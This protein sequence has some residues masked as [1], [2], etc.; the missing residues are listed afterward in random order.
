MPQPTTLPPL[1]IGVDLPPNLSAPDAISRT[2]STLPPSQL[3]DILAQMKALATNDPAKAAELLRQAPQL[4]YAIFQAML[5]MNLVSTEALGAVVE[6]A[7]A[8][9]PT[10]APVVQQPYAPPMAQGFA[11][12]QMGTP[13]VHGMQFPPPPPPQQGY[14]A[15]PPQQQMLPDQEQLRR[16]VMEMPQA[17]IDALAPPERAQIMALRQS[18]MAQ[19]Y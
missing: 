9:A 16:Q 5:L 15:P 4:A 3:L 7:A 10:P 17:I 6:A 19:G 1:P 14:Q 12:P 13:P 2:L 8:P 18:F 11:P